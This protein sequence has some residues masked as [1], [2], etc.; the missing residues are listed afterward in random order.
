MKRVLDS[1]YDHEEHDPLQYKFKTL[2]IEWDS[3]KQSIPTSNRRKPIAAGDHRLFQFHHISPKELMSS[4]QLQTD[5]SPS[6]EDFDDGRLRGRRLF[7]ESEVGSGNDD[8]ECFDVDG[9]SEVSTEYSCKGFENYDENCYQFCG[10]R[11]SCTDSPPCG[12]AVV[13]MKSG[14]GGRGRVGRLMV[15][16]VVMLAL[17]IVAFKCSGE[18]EFVLVPT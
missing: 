11:R 10:F 16:V 7:D 5:N 12:E 15:C 18:D 17:A 13:V 6:I 1:I 8:G 2:E 14:G 9:K 3:I 4:L